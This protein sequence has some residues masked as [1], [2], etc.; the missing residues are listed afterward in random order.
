MKIQGHEIVNTRKTK[1]VKGIFYKM[2]KFV[3]RDWNK[4]QE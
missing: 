3:C 1:D 4:N 2:N